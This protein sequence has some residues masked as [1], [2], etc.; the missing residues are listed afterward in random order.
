M[1]KL[2]KIFSAILGLPEENISPT[3]APQNTPA[4]DSLNAII[5]L[6]EI[7]QAFAVKFNYDQAM[8]I[9]NFADVLELI[10]NTG[11]DPYAE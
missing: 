2:T 1:S 10:K 9:K 4:W 8:S 5:L 3:L 7:E 11:L 6:T